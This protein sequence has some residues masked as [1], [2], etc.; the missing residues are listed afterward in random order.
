MFVERIADWAGYA[1]GQERASDATFPY[2]DHT[3]DHT[4][5]LA[6][7]A[8]MGVLRLRGVPF[9]LALNRQRNGH[10]RRLV[11]FLNAVADEN[12]Q[13]F[14]HC[15]KHDSSL[16]PPSHGEATAPYARQLLADYH[17]SIADELAVVDWFITVI[18][19][20]RRPPFA[21][22]TD[23]ARRVLAALGLLRRQSLA[24]PALDAQLEDAMRL[25]LA[26]LAPFGPSRLGIR[27]RLDPA[28]GEVTGEFSEIAEFLYLLRTTQFEPQPLAD[29]LG[30]LGAGIAAVDVTAV[31]GTKLLRIDHGASSA[32]SSVSW[33]AMLGLATYPRQLDQSRLDGLLAL[34]G[35]FVLTLA[36]RF[37]SRA[38]AQ[39]RIALLQRRLIAAGDRAVSDIEGLDDAM[40]EIAGGRAETGLSRWSLAL[41]GGTRVE[42][43]RLASAART[44]LV[45]AQAKVTLESA[46]RLS[47]FLAQLPGAP[48]GTWI[49]PARCNT[50]QLST[51]ATL[52]G[53][54]RGPATP[55][56]DHHLFRLLTPAGTAYDHDLFVGDVGHGVTIA[57]NGAGKT[58]WVGTCIAAVD[59][60]VSRRGGTQIVL[61]VDES[62]AATLLMLEGRYASI[63]VGRSGLAPLK[64][65]PDTPRVR[66]LLRNLIA[67]LV[68]TD[69]APAPT[70]EERAG[71]REGVDFVMGEMAPHERGLSVVRSFMGGYGEDDSAGARL[72]SWCAGQELGWVFD[73]DEHT[74]DFDHRLVGL[75]LTAVMD[76]ARI[77][78]PLAM[79]LLWM[80]SEVMDGRR[81]VI[82]CEEAPAYM[83][84]PAF[85]KPFKGIALRARKRNASFNAI[86]Q[87]VG[88][89]TGNEAGRA[90]VKQAR[91]FIL[92]PNDKAE[93]QEYC[94]GLGLT[95]SEFHAVREGMFTLPYHTVL[96][97]RQ[98][99]QSEVLRFDL[100]GLPQHL[101]VL[102]GTP[103]RVALLRRYLARHDGDTGRAFAEFQARIHETAA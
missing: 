62:N 52:A 1:G 49:R 70:A 86:A 23:K 24:D 13:V 63:Q 78:P 44:I 96:V 41:H 97:K 95:P 48:E 21:G 58:V 11:A 47:S 6:D 76:D 100:S 83:P 73:G 98:D 12:V 3:G 16:P 54:A 19:A 9:S 45:N 102:S 79:A 26:T 22:V 17:A 56:W 36:V 20:P 51:L 28:A 15:V 67:G 31:A 85:A 4:L 81:V 42:V 66:W 18:V 84:T 94:Q 25:G 92:F 87:Q 74:I 93:E 91:Q 55:R 5:L 60:A 75:D 65:L 29:V 40:D 35:R 89:M 71:I 103:R 38:Q 64:G 34:P 37:E 10:K 39:D 82:W 90:L 99:G 69:G 80:A 57:P 33:A 59:A 7:D 77:M 46:G 50:R 68:Q 61:D 43:D 72:E 32:A 88:D 14:V 2:V 101:N 30:F 27:E 53:Y 8:K